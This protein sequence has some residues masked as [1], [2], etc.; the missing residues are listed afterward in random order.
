MKNVVRF[1]LAVAVAMACSAV[2]HS[3]HAGHELAPVVPLGSQPPARLFADA[4][5]P[6]QLAQGLVAILY[7]SEN[8][9]IVPVFGSG[10]LDVSPR[11][12]HVPVT[13]NDAPWHWADASGEPLVIQGLPPGPH[14]VM[15]ELADPTHKVIDSQT[16]NF[17]IPK[18]R[19]HH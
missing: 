8:L 16:V 13:V 1:A 15:I 11:I 14:R 12:G 3:V 9:R 17:E 4:P 2:V 5:L 18:G 10:A 19:S 6:E 7:R